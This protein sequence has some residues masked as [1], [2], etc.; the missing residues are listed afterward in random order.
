MGASKNKSKSQEEYQKMFIEQASTAMAMVDNNMC[1]I[2]ASPSWVKDYGLEGIEIIGRSHYEIFPE[3]GDDWKDMHNRCLNGATDI[4]EETPFERTDGSVQWIYWDVRP[5]FISEDKIGGI[6]MHTGDVTRRK[7]KELEQARIDE[8]LE[9]TNEIAR[10]GTWEINLLTGEVYWSKITREIHEVS[11]DFVPT[12]DSGV[13]FFKEGE[14]RE[15][16]ENAIEKAREDGTHFN[17]EL[18]I[19][20]AKR[21]ICWTRVVGRVE[22]LEGKR[23]RL[24]GIV[25]DINNTKLAEQQLNKAH[26]ELQA[27]FNSKAIAIITTGRDGIINNFNRGAEVLL[28][29]TSAETVGINNPLLFVAE[30]ELVRFKN[31]LKQLYGER[32]SSL[33]HFEDI[34]KYIDLSKKDM[35]DT[36]EWTHRRKDG[37][38]FPCQTTVSS[39]KDENGEHTGF[40]AVLSDISEIKNAEEELLEKN[41]RLNF[42]EQISM[43]SNW[44]W[45]TIADKV[46]WSQNFYK[47]LEL[48]ESITELKFDSYFRFVHPEDIEIVNQHFEKVEKDKK[49]ESFT[50]R[51]ITTS[52]K[53]KII[54]LLGEVHTNEK[55]EIVEMVGTCQDVTESKMAERNLQKAHS[56]LTAIFNS[57]S[58]SIIT[59]DKNGVINR[60]NEGAEAILGYSA[61]EVVGKEKPELYLLKEEHSK[62]KSDI[63]KQ[64]GKDPAAFNYY[65]DSLEHDLNDTREWMYRRKDGV[66]VPVLATTSAIKNIDN[67]NEGYIAISKDISEIKNAESELLKN[68]QLLNY[69]E[70]I[71]KMAN[72]QWDPVADKGKSSKNLYKILELDEKI[73]DLQLD[74]YL[75]FVHPEDKEITAQHFE[76]AVKDKKWESFT[77]RIITTSGRVKTIQL[78]GE[79]FTNEKG[80]VIEITGTCQDVTEITMAERHLQ[81]AHS[82]LQAIFNSESI[83]II[84]TDKNGVINRFNHGA[85]LLLGYSAAEMVGI[86]KPRKY[87]HE[88]EIK[89]FRKDIA[90]L[91]G[92]DPAT[93][94]HY[95]N[96][97]KKELN[98]TRE[99]TYYKKDG[100][101]VSVLSTITTIKNGDNANEG[102]IA[103]SKDI[104]EI[105]NAES[106]L[107]KKNEQL[108]F[109]EQI[110]MMGHW[111][112]NTMA[113]TVKW[114]QNLYTVFEL[115]ETITNLNFDTYFGFVHP[116][117][118]EIVTQY[119]DKAIK[120]KKLNSFTHRIITTSGKLKTIHVLGEV[121]TNEKGEIVEMVGTSQDVTDIKM[122]EKKFR[123]L[124]ES[125]PDAM[126]IVNDRGTIQ[127]INKQSEKLFGYTP[128]ELID[129][130]V[131]ILIPTSFYPEHPT[132]HSSFFHTPINKEMGIGKDLYA[133]KKNGEEI[134]IQISLSP[135]HTEEGLLVSAAIRDITKRKLAE[136]KINEAKENLE[137]VAQKLSSQ[138]KQLADFTHITSHNLR[139]PVANLNSLLEIYDQSETEGDRKAI[140]SKFKTVIQHLTLTLN[141][142][143]DALKTKISDSKEDL[144]EIV[145]DDVLKHTKEILSGAI[146]NS[147][148]IIKSD[149]SKASTIRYNRIYMESIFL[150]LV[151]NAIKYKSEARIPEILI[152]S[153]VENEKLI[154][155]FQDNGL[156]ID[157]EQHGHKLFGL[158]KVFHRHPDAKGVG[159]FLTKTQIEAMGGAISACST[160]NVGTT[161]TIHFD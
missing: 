67:S 56:E 138:N 16:L 52:G 88:D 7:E 33:N 92:E 61:A 118:K 20:T 136:Q 100:S 159:L 123:G 14:S 140:F 98:D 124:L 156:G 133:L 115:D 99:W 152:T 134:P 74:I 63:A 113:D 94:D 105:K 91:N 42:A 57:N 66:I 18:E 97:F 70:Q 77:H 68:N 60:F 125:A 69:A 22:Y 36:R 155:K 58:I 4:C 41:D 59:T 47:I 95:E 144:E 29:Y 141:T 78:L 161:F 1:Y 72:W 71:S 44:K 103:I 2:A 117:D 148:A 46:Q 17:L 109:A 158:N 28:G 76:K 126:V 129:K 27:I 104:S 119:F 19:V 106:E 24:F 40:I 80:E 127:L 96:L 114:S 145:L 65:V 83:L 39:I 8:I 26:S 154:L 31:E 93:Y 112:W 37:S 121:H 51:I 151:G 81:K 130:P 87:I 108:N 90:V 111:Q 23:T 128:E 135:L 150:N 55:D 110:S 54:Q 12:L 139:A 53:V 89:E 11:E 13:N 107:L 30:Y 142:L 64:N 3:I 131:E 49:W 101:P 34:S 157:L 38:T 25:Q 45:D 102:F 6:L 15:K 21:N 116:E 43:L 48:D 146:L 82:E 149:F 62:F 9:K 86:E 153:E 32:S 122:A 147:G 10:I 132:H 35:D 143:V 75:D 160:V 137:L 79:V 5:W 73:T 50:H 85:E 84:T 120:H